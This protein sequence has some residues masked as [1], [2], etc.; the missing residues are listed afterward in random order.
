MIKE[1]HDKLHEIIIHGNRTPSGWRKQIDLV[2]DQF[3][4]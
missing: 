1:V 4:I 3:H 2:I